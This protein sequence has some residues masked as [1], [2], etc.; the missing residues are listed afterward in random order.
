M[1]LTFKSSIVKSCERFY[2][3]ISYSWAKN[4]IDILNLW[5]KIIILCYIN[6]VKDYGKKFIMI[7]SI[8]LGWLV[9]GFEFWE[10]TLTFVKLRSRSLFVARSF[11]LFLLSSFLD[12]WVDLLFKNFLVT[13]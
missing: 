11:S 12:L 7:F 4:R 1:S 2:I 5:E 10:I 3:S 13:S 6:I 9:F 8:G